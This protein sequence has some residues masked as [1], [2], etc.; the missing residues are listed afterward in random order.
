MLTKRCKKLYSGF[1]HATVVVARNA[2]IRLQMNANDR[3]E[4]IVDSARLR[5]QLQKNDGW[6]V[7]FFFGENLK[8]TLSHVE[9]SL[10]DEVIDGFFENEA[11]HMTSSIADTGHSHWI[12]VIRE[13]DPHSAGQSCSSRL[14]R[15]G[16][17]GVT[18]SMPK[19]SKK[20]T[21]TDKELSAALL[22]CVSATSSS[23]MK[24]EFVIVISSAEKK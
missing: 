9:N 10:W 17:Q 1:L 7:P 6:R 23:V 19:A 3:F 2:S 21:A 15:V 16:V 8:V 18:T 13:A 24:G 4:S 11:F 20:K 14:A 22:E 5:R 12:A